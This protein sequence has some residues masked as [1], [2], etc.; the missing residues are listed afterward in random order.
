MIR[1]GILGA[2]HLG[3]IHMKLLKSVKA[4]EIVGFYDNNSEV[5]TETEKETGLKVFS[6]PQ[7]L[8]NVC[9]AIDI[10]TPTPHHFTYASMAIKTAKH[11][12][13][14]KPITVNSEEAKKLVFL[15]REA[16][17]VAHAGHVERFNPAFLASEPEITR[18]VFIDCRRIASYNV[19][20][21]DV[22]V[23]LDLMVHDI[24]LVLHLIKSPV[25]KI[26]ATGSAVLCVTEDIAE[27]RIEFDNGSVATISATRVATHN[28]RKMTVFQK[29]NYF[30]MDFLEKTAVKSIV[31]ME[32]D[33]KKITHQKL[34]TRPIN[35]I[36]HE[37]QLFA[38]AINKQKNNAVTLEE[39]YNTMKI[40]DAIL[41]VIRK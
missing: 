35:A 38:D 13:I 25:K 3:K 40:A 16:N 33:V 36:E 20:G 9:D 6:S 31:E 2:G 4:F 8:I 17:I 24:D 10:V 30:S 39:A 34:E 14:E 29:D 22:S 7:D 11:I 15:A 12:F 41:E 27:A 1:I 26:S 37:L 23:V 18:P 28:L 5:A 32:N 21:T 19:R